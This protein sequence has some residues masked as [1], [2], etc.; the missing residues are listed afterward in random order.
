MITILAGILLAQQSA[1]QPEVSFELCNEWV[2]DDPASMQFKFG[3]PEQDG[4]NFALYM[5]NL[6]ISPRTLEPVELR[7]GGFTFEFRRQDQKRLEVEGVA[8]WVVDEDSESVLCLTPDRRKLVRIDRETLEVEATQVTEPRSPIIFDAGESLGRIIGDRSEPFLLVANRQMFWGPERL[9]SIDTA[10][11]LQPYLQQS[12]LR[13]IEYLDT[14]NPQ[15]ALGFFCPDFWKW[16]DEHYGGGPNGVLACGDVYTGQIHWKLPG[17]FRWIDRIEGTI[18]ALDRE[19]KWYTVLEASGR[20]IP[21]AP[22]P[23]MVERS[24]RYFPDFEVVDD[25]LVSLGNYLDER[26][27]RTHVV[28]RTYRVKRTFKDHE[29]SFKELTQ[30][31]VRP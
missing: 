12:P 24:G 20:T 18:L 26:M 2:F 29:N 14:S 17:R 6:P 5:R 15:R 27:E 19:G 3:N 21:I 16:W 1:L 28:L 31:L 4:R 13:F 7:T 10:V 30:G 8:Y 22:Y 9:V 25:L 11:I 23:T